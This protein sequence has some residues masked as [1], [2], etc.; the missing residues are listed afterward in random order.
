MT[1][2]DPVSASSRGVG[3]V[4]NYCFGKAVALSVECALWLSFSVAG[5]VTCNPA[6]I[7]A[8][9]KFGNMAINNLFD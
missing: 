3:L 5:G 1:M 7:A 6:L 9:A 4:F 2:T 8:G